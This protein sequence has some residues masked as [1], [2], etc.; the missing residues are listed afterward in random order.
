MQTEYTPTSGP[1]A[2]NKALLPK[3]MVAIFK[4]TSTYLPTI[5]AIILSYILYPSH[6]LP[7]L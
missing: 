3:N 1:A 7:M 5:P 6:I 2:M 4:W